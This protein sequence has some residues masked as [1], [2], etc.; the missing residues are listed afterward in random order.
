MSMQPEIEVFILRNKCLFFRKKRE[1]NMTRSSRHQK[2]ISSI[3]IQ[4]RSETT[5]KTIIH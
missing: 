3:S 1:I 2:I 5:D 4:F